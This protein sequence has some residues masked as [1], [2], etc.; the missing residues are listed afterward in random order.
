MKEKILYTVW[1]CFYILCVGLGFIQ[2]PEGLGKAMLV[3]ISLL[4][5]VPGA[6]LLHDGVVTQSRKKLLRLRLVCITSL[7]LTCT[8]L[9]ASFLTVRS[10]AAVGNLMHEVLALVSAPMLCSQ[11]W[12]LSLFL[13]A[14]LLMASIFFRPKKA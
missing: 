14:C 12:A 3:L 8:A 13:W 4:F 11:Y 7:V 5:F 10:S 2:Q 9:I 6:L 1:G